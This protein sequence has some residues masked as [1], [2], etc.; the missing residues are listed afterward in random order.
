MSLLDRFRVRRNGFKLSEV[1]HFGT[2]RNPLPIPFRERLRCSRPSHALF[3]DNAFMRNREPYSPVPF[4][5]K[6]RI[7]VLENNRLENI[8]ASF[9][10]ADS[11][12]YEPEKSR[13]VKLSSGCMSIASTRSKIPFSPASGFITMWNDL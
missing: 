9:L 5:D 13:F 11:P 4:L 3:V 1:M 12:M 2:T 7:F 6:L 10:V 8:S